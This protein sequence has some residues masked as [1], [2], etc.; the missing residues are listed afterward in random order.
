MRRGGGFVFDLS[1]CFLNKAGTE[2]AWHSAALLYVRNG[3]WGD[4]EGVWK[5][6]YLQ[7]GST[8]AGYYLKSM[9]V[10][11]TK[12]GNCIKRCAYSLPSCFAGCF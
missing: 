6:L 1:F 4:A 9:L 7:E 12:I 5:G 11:K 10:R 8:T 2:K 3:H